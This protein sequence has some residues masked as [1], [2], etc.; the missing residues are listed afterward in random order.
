M[1]LRDLDPESAARDAFV[2][3][4]NELN[5]R[6]AALA[7]VRPLEMK[8]GRQSMSRSPLY[9]AVLELARF[10]KTGIAPRETWSPDDAVLSLAVWFP[11][12]ELYQPVPQTMLALVIAAAWARARLQAGQ[13]LTVPEVHALTGLDRDHITRLAQQGVI[14]GY[15]SDETK[16]KPW[17]FRPTAKL[18][19]WIES[20]LTPDQEATHGTASGTNQ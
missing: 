14:P 9:R 11:D 12:A 3:V 10:A 5:R 20:Y 8:V 15:R 4:C 19:A 13:D 7:T 16:H 2:T 18:R 17:K 1:R 6:V